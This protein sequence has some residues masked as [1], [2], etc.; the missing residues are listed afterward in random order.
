MSLL[1]ALFCLVRVTLFCASN[2]YKESA[3]PYCVDMRL[4]Q[5]YL[6]AA[7]LGDLN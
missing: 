4:F 2:D 3:L 7:S 6:E 1:T 5:F